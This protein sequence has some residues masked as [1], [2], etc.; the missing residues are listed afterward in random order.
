MAGFDLDRLRHVF[1]ANVVHDEA[2]ASATLTH[3]F[4]EE[5]F[6]RWHFPSFPVVPGVILLDG[7]MLAAV[8][9][10]E[11]LTGRS[12]NEIDRIAVDSATFYR[13][14]LPG[15]AASFTARADVSQQAAH[16]FAARCSVMIAGTRHARASMSF[17]THGDRVSPEN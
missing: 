10:F 3:G 6:L 1:G 15:M 7:M 17:H 9:A 2:K 12:G 16:G 4:G 5:D 14:V 8:R 11:R 13:P